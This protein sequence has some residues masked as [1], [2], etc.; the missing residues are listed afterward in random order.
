MVK[1]YRTSLKQPNSSRLHLSV[2]GLYTTLSLILTWPLIA[3]ITTHVPGI[4]QWA[5]DESTFIWNIWY[6]KH[7]LVDQLSSPLHTDLIW[8]PLGIDLVLYT[9]NFFHAL[10]AQ[11]LAL[12]VNLPFGSNV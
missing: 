6:L 3:Q 11:P 9:Y 5:F 8:Y 2:L 7:T 4:A 12:A 10:I 1:P